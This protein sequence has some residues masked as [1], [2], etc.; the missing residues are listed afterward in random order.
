MPSADKKVI[1]KCAAAAPGEAVTTLSCYTRHSELRGWG[2]L[3]R[4]FLQVLLQIFL[5]KIY[6]P[7]LLE[8][9]KPLIARFIVDARFMHIKWILSGANFEADVAGVGGEAGHVPG[10]NVVGYV[11]PSFARIFTVKTLERLL[12]LDHAVLHL[13]ADVSRCHPS[14]QWQEATEETLVLYAEVECKI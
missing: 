3:Q 11:L 5:F 6:F 14:W 13:L 1:N 8:E 7:V 4:T 10:L 9:R 2:M 12:H